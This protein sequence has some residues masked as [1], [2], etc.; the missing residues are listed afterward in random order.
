M[1]RTS[2]DPSR[3]ARRALAT[4]ALSMAML[5]AI[6]FA[7]DPVQPLPKRP[8]V[9]ALRGDVA[10]DAGGRGV[11]EVVD[12]PPAAEFLSFQE[13]KLSE[14]YYLTPV[15]PRGFIPFQRGLVAIR[16]TVTGGGTTASNNTGIWAEADFFL[17]DAGVRGNLV[18]PAGPLQLVA[19]EG[20][21]IPSREKVPQ[22]FGA[23]SNLRFGE[24]GVGFSANLL[25]SGSGVFAELYT[26]L[27][28]VLLNGSSVPEGTGIF[29]I[30]HPPAIRDSG[31]ALVPAHLDF[32]TTP[33]GPLSDTGIWLDS[34]G[35]RA[36]AV[37]E[38]SPVDGLPGMTF[39]HCSSRVVI[40]NYCGFAFHS[41]VTGGMG[42][43]NAIFRGQS[44][45]GDLSPRGFDGS[46]FNFE[47][48]VISRRDDI[49][50]GTEG[51]RFQTYQAEAMSEEG[52]VAFRGQLLLAPGVTSQNNTGLWATAYGDTFKVAQEGD[53]AIDSS[54]IPVYFDNFREL[55]YSGR[56]QVIFTAFLR[57]PQVNSAND[58]SLW[59]NDYP[60]AG[61]RGA[62]PLPHSNRL[63]AREGD[64]APYTDGSVYQQIQ[65]VAANDNA[66]IAY[67]A[68]LNTG[69][70][71]TTTSN[72]QGLWVDYGYGAPPQLL[73]RKGDP[74]VVG[75]DS[76]TGA[77]IV[78]EVINIE[79][80]RTT[81]SAGGAGGYGRVLND[82]DE[83]VVR[84]VLNGGESGVFL[85]N[86]G[87]IFD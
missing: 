2:N 76:E 85:W 52:N 1:N 35:W 20:N 66:S 67:V 44:F 55:F 74:I 75:F 25:P 41:Y 13:A 65:D 16:A 84:L 36:T 18:G 34:E 86:G 87:L 22:G 21:P 4:T 6:T 23:F 10:P 80:D 61:V 30:L 39:G 49:A 43:N 38:G 83:I 19:R 78:R 71:D 15:S 82:N 14:S 24:G 60:M 46:F 77:E 27:D 53:R 50:P 29:K 69:I 57:G 56:G 7:G 79:I 28:T 81:N 63:I 33:D 73:V 72:N 17:Q 45:A 5:P 51:A 62:G 70:G 31:H 68:T 48:E 12:P 37:R 54:K 59:V 9:I 11:R 3:H 64:L 32:A 40:D 8:T 26:P 58:S 42:G 47:F